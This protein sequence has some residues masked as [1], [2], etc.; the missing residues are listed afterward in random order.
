MLELTFRF[1]EFKKGSG[2]AKNELLEWVRKQIPEYNIKD[3]TSKSASLSSP[4]LCV[5]KIKGRKTDKG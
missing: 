3:F 4:P 5:C 1:F 2:S